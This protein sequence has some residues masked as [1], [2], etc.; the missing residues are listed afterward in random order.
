VKR[1]RK[2]R[3]A[4]ILTWL[5]TAAMVAPIF[6]GIAMPSTAYAQGS[7][8]SGGVQTVIVIDFTNKAGSAYDSLARLATDAVAV[9]LANSGRFEVLKR[10]EVTRAATELGLHAPYDQ[11]A[12]SKLAMQLGASGIV[13]GTIAFVRED[14][15]STPHTVKVGLTI[16]I[17]EASSGDLINGAA[18]IGEARA[19]PGL[20]DMASLA[21][22]ATNNAAIAG[23]R[24]ILA[25]V[26]PEGTILSTVGSNTGGS[27][28]IIINRGSR[29]GVQPGMQFIVLRDRQRVGRIEATN[30]FPT[31]SEAKVIDIG[32]GIRPEDKVRAVFPMPE[33]TSHFE[34]TRARPAHRG[35][36]M[37]ALGKVL[38]VLVAGVVLAT[39]AKGGSSSVTGV[40]AEPTVVNGGPAVRI[41][42]RDNM[43]GNSLQ[44]LEYHVW[45]TPDDPFN[46]SGTP[47]A[48]LPQVT[49]TYT[50]Q[51]APYSFWDG[52]R[53]FLQPGVPTTGGN[54]GN[55][56]NNGNTASTKTPAAGAVTGFPVTGNTYQYAVTSVIRRPVGGSNQGTGG[57]VNGGGGNGTTTGTEDIETSQVASGPAT[58]VNIPLLSSPLDQALNVDLRNVVFQWQSRTGADVFQVEVSTDRTFKNRNLIERF[59]VFSTAPQADGVTQIFKAPDLSRDAVLLRDP[60]FASFVNR[61]PGA[62]TP[63]VYWRVGGR[64]SG[65]RP[66]P[67]DWMTGNHTVTDNTFRFIYSQPRAFSPAPLPPPPP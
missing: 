49:Y 35:A 7:A 2:S 31:D 21:Q 14:T 47:I 63:V 56:G 17:S 22:E 36:S 15:K 29:D 61:V 16:R 28:Q 60:A 59:Q 6:S 55:G 18:Q 10:D 43:F 57:G 39:A 4:R 67:V 20:S 41:V 44:T 12:R 19:R 58:P 46:Y 54:G 38:M 26:L 50:D 51:P 40:V 24:Q 11:I 62:A 34:V 52:N 27:L 48:A 30:V 65:D 32:L 33:F 53:S 45:R 8:Q 64:N 23:V 13:D 66:G 1:I 3:A 9:E 5:L 37:S 25:N 42:W